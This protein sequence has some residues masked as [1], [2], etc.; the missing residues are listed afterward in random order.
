[1]SQMNLG[2]LFAGRLQFQISHAERLL[3]AAGWQSSHD[4]TDAYIGHPTEVLTIRGNVADIALTNQLWLFN[5]IDQGLS[6]LA[7]PANVDQPRPN[8]NEASIAFLNPRETMSADETYQHLV[9]VNTAIVQVIEN[10]PDEEFGKTVVAT[11][12]GEEP[13]HELFFDLLTHAD[14]HFGQAWA[15]IKARK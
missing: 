1:M 8:S 9:D 2:K 14:R 11:F 15:I 12:Y 4:W 3:K 13:F 5:I 6:R 10:M 7:I